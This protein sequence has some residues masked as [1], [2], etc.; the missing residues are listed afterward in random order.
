M[1]SHSKNDTIGDHIHLKIEDRT[2]SNKT[3]TMKIKVLHRREEGGNPASTTTT[4]NR[5]DSTATE[6]GT[7]SSSSSSSDYS[8]AV[9]LAGGIDLSNKAI[10]PAP[11]TE[12]GMQRVVRTP[13]TRLHPFQRER[14]YVR[15][16]NATKIDKMFAKPFVAS[17][18]LH[19]DAIRAMKRSNFLGSVL[20]SGACDGSVVQ[21][22]LVNM[23]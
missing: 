5:R 9:S 22:D 12:K 23:R 13:D 2:F 15:A 10:A 6:E 3:D 21:W 7:S 8:P 1:F 14:E 11:A 4:S 18:E 17:L 19:N 20:Y 16:L